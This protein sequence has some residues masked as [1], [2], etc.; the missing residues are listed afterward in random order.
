MKG[1]KLVWIFLVEV[2]VLIILSSVLVWFT[3]SRE[4]QKESQPVWVIEEDIVE[5]AV[6]ENLSDDNNEAMNNNLLEETEENISDDLGNQ[7]SADNTAKIFGQEKETFTLLFAGDVLFDDNYSPMAALRQRDNDISQCFS[8]EIL[9]EMKDADVFV[10]NNEFTLSDRGEP[11]EGKTYTFRGK[12]ENVSYYKDMGV[13]LVSLANNHAY[14]YGEVSL[15]DTLDI[16]D[17][18]GIAR[19]GGGKNIEEASAPFVIE[20]DDYKVAVIAA[21]QIERLENP[22][23]RGATEDSPGVFRCLNP[24]KLYETVEKAKEECDYV[25]VYI[26]WGTENVF[27]PDWLQLDQAKGLA[28]AG[29]DIIIGNHSHCIQPVDIVDGVPVVY[30]VANFWFNSKE[31]INGMLKVSFNKEGLES[32]QF[33]PGLQKGN[34]T[35]LLSGNEKIQALE[36]IQSMKDT[37]VLDDEGFFKISVD[38]E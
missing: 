10:V 4:R 23:T 32:V 7:D 17:E 20:L 3:L 36:M 38:N 37:K 29:A 33:L 12:P 26:H 9:K 18:A 31:V 11:T 34:Y 14:D 35:S 25:I 19:I 8:S 16:L 24:E 6:A 1:K 28:Q 30:S 27:E 5:E 2:I 13:D 15:L 22:D 21:T